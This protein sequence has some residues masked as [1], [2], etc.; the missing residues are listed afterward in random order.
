MRWILSIK[1]LYDWKHPQNSK[2]AS[3]PFAVGKNS[4]RVGKI[5]L[6]TH[7]ET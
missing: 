7:P 3:N 1:S 5:I 2:C 6:P 4:I